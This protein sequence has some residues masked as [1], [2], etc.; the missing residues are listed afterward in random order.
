MKKFKIGVVVR[1]LDREFSR[2]IKLRDKKCQRCG[3]EDGTLQCSHVYP[4]GTYRSM[5]WEP[6]NAKLLCYRCHLW[7]HLNPVLAAD[8]LREYLGV[9]KV[10]LLRDAS[11]ITQLVDRM[12]L[13]NI[14]IKLKEFESELTAEAT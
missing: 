14:E 8:W 1:R 6:D 7:W 12:F 10:N 11:Q 5:R 2:L 4:K 9:T 3:R 13:L